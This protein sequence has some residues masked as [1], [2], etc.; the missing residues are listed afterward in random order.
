MANILDKFKSTSVGSSGR[1]VDYTSTITSS[2]DFTQIFDIDAILKSW[3]NILTTPTGSADHDPPFGCDLYLYI[4]EPAD[5]RTRQAIRDE[6]IRSLSTYD[7]RA[8]ISD[9]EISFFKNRKG[10][11][12][13]ITVDYSGSNSDISL[14]VDENTYQNLI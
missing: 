2:G 7:D 1:V 9:I 11:T 4:F 12:V 6:I 8:N 10:F 13:N 14:V 5:D 3:K